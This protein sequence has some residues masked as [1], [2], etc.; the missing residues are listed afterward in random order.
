MSWCKCRAEIIA[1]SVDGTVRRFDIR[2]G[3]LFIDE[4]H[5]PVSCVAASHDGHCILA[6]C[7]DSTIRLLDRTDGDLLAEYSGHNHASVKMDCCFTPLD[8]Y[9]VGS[10]EDGRVLFWEVVNSELVQSFQ[11]HSDAVTSMAMHDSVLLTS[12]IDGLIRVWV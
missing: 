11:A 2:M 8:G 7:M 3:R 12:S 9:V 10:S 6:A 1:G 5:H 4:M